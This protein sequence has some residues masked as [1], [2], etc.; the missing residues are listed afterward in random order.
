MLK[1]ADRWTDGQLDRQDRET[2][3]QLDRQ[4]DIINT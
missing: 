4:T 3:G 2:D 1:L